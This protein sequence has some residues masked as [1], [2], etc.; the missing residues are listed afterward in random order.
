MSIEAQ[1]VLP[2]D[3]PRRPVGDYVRRLTEAGYPCREEPDEYGHWLVFDGLES[4]LIFSVEDGA[5]VFVTFEMSLSDPDEA[6]EGVGRVFADAGWD[7][8]PGEYE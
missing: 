3:S 8:E 6:I 7:T 5:A 1:F 2:A 4:R